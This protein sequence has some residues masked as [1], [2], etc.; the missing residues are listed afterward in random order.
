MGRLLMMSKVLQN[1]NSIANVNESKPD[2]VLRL[3][4]TSL[5]ELRGIEALE[6]MNCGGRELWGRAC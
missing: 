5:I 1:G 3:M 4:S 2:L 6:A